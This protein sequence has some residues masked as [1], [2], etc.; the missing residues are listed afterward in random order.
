MMKDH[1]KPIAAMGKE[2]KR[3]QQHNPQLILRWV[4]LTPFLI[5]LSG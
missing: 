5:L 2:E 3:L 4:K 1:L